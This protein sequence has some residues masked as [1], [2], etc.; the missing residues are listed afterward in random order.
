M[1][2]DIALE[3]KAQEISFTIENWK[4]LFVR[5]D[6]KAVQDTVST[7]ILYP[8]TNANF[9]DFYPGTGKDA[10]IYVHMVKFDDYIFY[11]ISFNNN[12][13]NSGTPKSSIVKRAHNSLKFTKNYFESGTTAKVWIMR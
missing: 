8:F 3:E 9:C 12:S 13:G 6:A 2:A 4:E 5:I 7:T 10:S 1:F 11:E